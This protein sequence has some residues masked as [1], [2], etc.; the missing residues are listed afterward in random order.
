[1]KTGWRTKET[2]IFNIPRDRLPF[3]QG[4]QGMFQDGDVS[5]QENTLSEMYMAIIRCVD[6]ITGKFKLANYIVVIFQKLE[7]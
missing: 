1:M 3:M 5:W 7:M 2:Y 6:K 4:R